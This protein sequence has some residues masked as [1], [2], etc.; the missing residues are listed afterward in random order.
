M[1]WLKTLLKRCLPGN[2]SDLCSFSTQRQS[3]GNQSSALNRQVFHL[4]R[5]LPGILENRPLKQSRPGGGGRE[6]SFDLRPRCTG[7]L[8]PNKLKQ[9][10]IRTFFFLVS[11][12]TKKLLPV[13]N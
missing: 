13:L 12:V 8:R 7:C 9:I 3:V 6:T 4:G 1:N 11:M 2:S 10:A 5:Y